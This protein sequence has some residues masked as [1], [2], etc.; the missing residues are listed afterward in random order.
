[1]EVQVS[2]DGLPMALP[3]VLQAPIRGGHDLLQALDAITDIAR[4]ALAAPLVLQHREGGNCVSANT[5]MP[6]G[7]PCIPVEMGM[8]LQNAS[9]ACWDCDRAVKGH[10]ACPT[11]TPRQCHTESLACAVFWSFGARGS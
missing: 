11:P 8:G 5:Q 3:V 4:L 2:A 10:M 7:N 6:A 1:M 9:A